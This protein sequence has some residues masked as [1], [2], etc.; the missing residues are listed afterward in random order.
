MGNRKNDKNKEEYP[1]LIDVNIPMLNLRNDSQVVIDNVN[2][3]IKEYQARQYCSAFFGTAYDAYDD[4]DWDDYYDD[5]ASAYDVSGWQKHFNGFGMTDEEWKEWQDSIREY[6]SSMNDLES[7]LGQPVKRNKKDKKGGFKSQKFINGIEVDDE[8]FE[9]HNKGSKHTRRGGRKHRTRTIEIINGVKVI[10]SPNKKRKTKYVDD[11][12]WESHERDAEYY[13]QSQK[14]DN[15]IEANKTIIFYRNLPDKTDTYEW[16]NLYEFDEWAREN[17]IVISDSIAYDIMYA[18][19]VHC[20][21]DPDTTDKELI[22]GY[23]YDG[24]AYKATN[25]DLT[26]LEDSTNHWNYHGL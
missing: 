10:S 16:D 23:D 14:D 11:D 15:E 18:S 3:L 22:M 21:L 12:W 13:Q 26:I 4:N 5:E 7:T 1:L 20:C 6:E 25:G 2:R 17:D 19:E 9:A 8:T 24:L